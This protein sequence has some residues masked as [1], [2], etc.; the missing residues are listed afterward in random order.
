MGTRYRTASMRRF[1]PVPTINALS[2]NEKNIIFFHLKINIFCS[3]EI[4]LYIAWVC[5][6]NDL[7]L[8]TATLAYART[9]FSMIIDISAAIY[10]H[11]FFFLAKV[12]KTNRSRKLMALDGF[13]QQAPGHLSPLCR[14]CSRDWWD[15]KLKKSQSILDS[16]VIT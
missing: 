16:E 4:L 5:L 1:L 14:S 10:F 11:N 6:R 7:F 2:K 12:T 9:I 13:K 8:Q 15:K 3:R